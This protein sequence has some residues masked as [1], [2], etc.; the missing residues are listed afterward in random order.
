MLIAQA[1]CLLKKTCRLL[2]ET[3]VYTEDDARF[4]YGHGRAR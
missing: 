2:N 4:I 1:I 3:H